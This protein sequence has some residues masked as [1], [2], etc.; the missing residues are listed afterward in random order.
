MPEEEKEESRA[1]SSLSHGRCKLG[2]SSYYA[3]LR[4]QASSQAQADMFCFPQMGIISLFGSQADSS[5]SRR[6]L[7]G[8]RPQAA[9]SFQLSREPRLPV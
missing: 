5:S 7:G 6:G 4:R 8:G 9:G 3:S 1:C 2:A